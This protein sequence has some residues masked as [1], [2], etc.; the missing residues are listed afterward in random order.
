M[1]KRWH[2]RQADEQ[3]VQR[4]CEHFKIS[5]IIARILA[6]RGF[7]EV[8]QAGRFLSSSL[9]SDLPSPSLMAGMDR[10]V[11]RLVEALKAKELVCVWGDYDVD[12]TTGAAVLVTFLREIGGHP[13]Y[14]IPHRINEGYGL[15]AEGLA[16]LAEKGV[17]LVVTVDCG[18]SNRREVEFALR[19][20][21]DIII[22]DHHQPPAD[23]PQAHAILNPHRAD[24]PFPDKGPS[25]VGVAFYLII[26]LRAR[27]REL[28]WFAEKEEPD[29]RRYLDIVTLGTVADLVPLTGV[30]RVLVRRGLEVLAKSQRPG[31][32]AL[33]QVA[34]INGEI[35][36]GQVGF[37][38]GPRINAAGRVDAAL[39]VVEMLTTE[40]HE[41]AQ[42]I[43]RE[44]DENNRE[45]QATEARVLEEA[46]RWIERSEGGVDHRYSIVLGADGWH[47]GV[48]GIVASRVLER[49]HR[50]TVVVGFDNGEGKG[51]ARSIRGFH[52]V[53]ALTQCADCLEKF[54]GHE[55]AGGLS[56]KQEKFSSFAERFE[57]VARGLLTAEDL[58]PVLEIDAELK[59]SEIGLDLARRIEA[60]HPFGI[61]NP[62][63]IF[64]SHGVEIADRK[65]FNG[66]AR[67]RLRQEGRVLSGVAFRLGN[68]VPLAPETKVDLLYR[69]CENEWN[70]S[71]SV[72]LRVLDARVPGQF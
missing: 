36:A 42:R 28:G 24:C 17:R 37:Q 54:G 39:K 11:E 49:F 55:Y 52:L 46:L 33:K 6:H 51:S 4:L 45:R 68:D 64:M 44:L 21:V 56:I 58:K 31:I 63:P 26:G 1:E 10:A 72:E 5:P 47:P 9:R 53:Q 40:S 59:F 65:D 62:E 69:V 22:V 61:G 34:G 43:A 70:G 14:Y 7:Q 23:L 35:G 2:L 15:N 3:V 38:L 50:P 20:G 25:A 18:I 32:V 27:L 12:G 29:L 13:I 8:E 57:E 66:G 67:F 41:V 16:Q 60:L 71:S 48:L 19:M 30:N